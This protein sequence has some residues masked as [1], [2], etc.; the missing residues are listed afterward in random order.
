MFYVSVEMRVLCTA[1]FLICTVSG[2]CGVQCMFCLD[3]VCYMS[4]VN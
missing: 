1:L 3:S 4:Y 2:V